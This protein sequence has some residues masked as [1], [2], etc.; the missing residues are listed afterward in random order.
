MKRKRILLWLGLALLLFS[1]IVPT[2]FA[3]TDEVPMSGAFSGVG[4][5]FSG[6]AAHLGRFEGVIDNTTVPPTAVWTA[7]NG[8]T[9][10]NMT[11]SFVI[12][13]SSPI[14][15]NVYPYT[16]TIEF[17][18]GSGRFQQATGSATITGTIDVVTFAY[19][20]RING[21]ISRPNSD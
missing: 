2:S 18:G 15:P 8:D 4:E 6:H 11:S 13:F 21:A 12:D 14:A 17:T 7:A 19:N 5:T 16:Q 10:T 3:M 1:L 20:G 9:L